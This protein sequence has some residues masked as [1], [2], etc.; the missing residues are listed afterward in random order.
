MIA[1]EDSLRPETAGDGAIP[2]LDMRNIGKSF[3]NIR[4]L[5]NVSFSVRSG[6]IHALMGENG[7]GKSTLM[8]ILSGAYRA[9]A[10]GEIRIRGALA[11]IDGPLSGRRH[12]IAVIYQELSLAPNLSV[13]ENIFLGEEKWRL[14]FIDRQAMEAAAAPLLK[15][16]DAP[17]SAGARVSTLSIAERQLVEIARALAGHPRILVMDEPTTS[18]S[19]RE[20]AR[21]FAIIRQLRDEGIAI[22]YISHRMG[23][24]Y[25]LAD[26][27]SVLRDGTLIGTLDKDEINAAAVVRMMVGR[28]LSSF[29]TKEHRHP[30][31][32]RKAVLEVENIGDGRFVKECSLSVKAGEVV[33]LAGLVGSG[34]TELAR[35]IYGADAKA[36][37]RILVDGRECRIETPLQAIKSGIVYLTEDRKALGLFLD[38]TIRENI[39]ISVLDEDALPGG[40]LNLKAARER[41]ATAIRSLGIRTFNAGV[42]VGALSGGNQQKVLL[43]RLLETKP[44]VLLLDEPTRGIDVGAKSQIY[45]IIDE[46]ARGGAAILVIS[47]EL[48]EIVGIS[49]RVL[50]MRDGQIVGEVEGRPDA[51]I[52]QEKIMDIATSTAAL[53]AA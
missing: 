51:P 1:N 35:L 25:E 48:P 43:S 5:S 15:R 41:A 2:E 29:Y 52:T 42:A 36:G 24:V 33:G 30:P 18:L 7:A 23:E 47:S 11:A 9:D 39:S 32:D 14:G 10:G 28:E 8:K 6:E 50:V 31:A 27:V 37:G 40:V 3:A 22:V 20:A 13:A 34:R 44:R 16:L 38:M 21:L 19:A 12:G 49:D 46:L 26:R 17:F 4:A 53:S 45:H